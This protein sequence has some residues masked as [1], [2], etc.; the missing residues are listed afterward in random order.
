[1]PGLLLSHLHRHSEGEGW[2][3]RLI[4]MS[5]SIS[6]PFL[7][8]ASPK[9]PWPL[10]FLFAFSFMETPLLSH[11]EN[12][13]KS[14]LDLVLPSLCALRLRV[15]FSPTFLIL[16]RTWHSSLEAT[17]PGSNSNPVTHFWRGIRP[18]LLLYKKKV[19]KLINNLPRSFWLWHFWPCTL[20]FSWPFLPLP[21][22]AF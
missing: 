5:P 12:G 10:L 2:E 9:W 6:P 13:C 3:N 16:H 22:W 11:Q 19:L 17:A 7:A 18:L 20:P 15:W 14:L 1:M 21:T 4:E 8:P